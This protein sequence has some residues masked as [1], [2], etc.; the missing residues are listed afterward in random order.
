MSN[1]TKIPEQIIKVEL[2]HSQL[3]N[4]IGFIEYEFIGSIR[5][6]DDIDNINYIINMSDA[7][8]TLRNTKVAF[9]R[10]DEN[11]N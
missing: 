1:L 2:T 9:D 5:R 10:R 6:N 4:L 7:L 11:D 8:K 3:H